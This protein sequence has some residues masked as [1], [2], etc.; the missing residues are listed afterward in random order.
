MIF[1]RYI[2]RSIFSVVFLFLG[3]IYFLYILIDYSSRVSA[4]ALL[5][6]DLSTLSFY[7]LALF[8]R[9][10]EVLFPFSLLLGVL[11][12]LQMIQRQNGWIAML[13]SGAPLRRL[14]LPFAVAG[15]AG[16]ALLYLNEQLLLP[17]ALRELNYVENVYFHK[18]EGVGDTN[19]RVSVRLS[20]GSR[21]YFYSIDPINKELGDVWYLPVWGEIWHMEKFNVGSKMGTHVDHFLQ[22]KDVPFAH[23]NSFLEHD[24]ESI[25]FQWSDLMEMVSSPS[26]YSITGLVHKLAYETEMGAAERQET[27]VALLAK[28]LMPWLAFLVCIAP[29]SYGITFSRQSLFFWIYL[30][31]IFSLLAFYLVM[32]SSIILASAS[33][34]SPFLAI[35]IPFLA[36]LSFF[37]GVTIRFCRYGSL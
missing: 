5:R 13:S 9:S 1:N 35:G 27:R 2:F 4:Q 6:F 8:I 25:D 30:V 26:S 12:T 29:L 20:K 17:R 11:K 19:D 7:Y 21:L 28:L 3:C 32:K 31:A 18:G 10:F 36:I 23:Q 33:I 16:T 34:L 37:G 24:F 15:L 22:T 14:L